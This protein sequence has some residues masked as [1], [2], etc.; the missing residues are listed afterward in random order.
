MVVHVVEQLETALKDLGSNPPEFQAFSYFLFF[1]VTPI[2]KY[3][4]TCLEKICRSICKSCFGIQKNYLKDK[5]ISFEI[6]L[7][8][9]VNKSL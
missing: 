3:V 1:P 8:D 5:T 9:P 4:Y 7:H 6:S 2:E